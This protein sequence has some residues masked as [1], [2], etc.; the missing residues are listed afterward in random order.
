[1]F[2]RR[3]LRRIF[4]CKEEE[5]IGGWG[6]LHFQELYVLYSSL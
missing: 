5:E 2:G 6:K 4:G 1:V 3:V